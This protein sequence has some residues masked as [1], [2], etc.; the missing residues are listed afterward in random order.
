MADMLLWGGGAAPGLQ[1]TSNQPQIPVTTFSDVHHP[2]MFRGPWR[3]DETTQ[4]LRDPDSP[5]S[6]LMDNYSGMGRWG[7]ESTCASDPE[8]KWVTSRCS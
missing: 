3:E 6:Y 5:K 1:V 7:T 8:R 2:A 4:C